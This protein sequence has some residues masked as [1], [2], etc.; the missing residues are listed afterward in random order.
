MV[1][2]YSIHVP[3]QALEDLKDRLART[4]WLGQVDGAGLGYGS[5]LEYMQELIEHWRSFFDRSA[6]VEAL[7]RSSHF[8][9]EIV[10][11]DIH[12]ILVPQPREWAGRECNVVHWNEFSKEVLCRVGGNGTEG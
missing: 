8:R 12:F 2:P 1:Q 11:L 5:D 10:G 7:K 4:R 6:Q 3:P 9:T